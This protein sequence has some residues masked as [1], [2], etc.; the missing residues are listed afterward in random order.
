MQKARKKTVIGL[1]GGSFNPAH[2]GHL[3]ISNYARK[4]LGLKQVWWL[5][6]PQNPLKQSNDIL[7]YDQRVA[8]AL[9]LIKNA[10]I[11]LSHFERQNHLFHSYHTAMRLKS[12]YPHYQFIWLMGEDCLQELPRWYRWRDFM[13]LMPIAVFRRNMPMASKNKQYKR[14]NLTADMKLLRPYQYPNKKSRILAYQRPPI[15]VV[16]K[17]PLC[18]LSSTELRK[19]NAI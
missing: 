12:A 17:Q 1:L 18:P 4:R 3:S 16:F 15:W 2:A 8:H 19:N 6:N 11:K 5:I 14:K 9:K 13:R 10:H 7:P